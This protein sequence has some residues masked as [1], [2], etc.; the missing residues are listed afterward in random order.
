M[1]KGRTAVL[2]FL[3]IFLSLAWSA[4]AA[5]E[6]GGPHR[7][8]M[9]VVQQGETAFSIARRYGTTVDAITH[10]N[11][12]ADPRQIYVGQQLLIP[13]E[14][15]PVETWSAHVVE[16]GETLAAISAR[17]GVSW[18]SLALSNQVLNPHLI[19]PGQVLRLP[20][21]L[22]RTG[23]LYAVDAGETLLEIAFRH[24]LL[25]WSLVETNKEIN[26]A[27]V[28]PGRWLL[29]PGAQPATMPAPFLAVD[30]TPMP[31]QQGQTLFITVR[32]SEPV[33]LGGSLFDRPLSFF[34]DG[35]V[36]RAV[37]GVHTFADP[38]LYEIALV[39]TD[40]GGRQVSMSTGLVVTDQRYG[41]E[42]IDL[43]PDRSNLLDPALTVAEREK[44]DAVRYTH[45]ASRHWTGPFQ[46]PVEGAIS[47][48]F[49]T[50]RSY[51][52]SPYTSYHSGVDFNVGRGTLVRAPA[53]GV[54]L[55][56]EQLVVRGNVVV[57]DHGY[58]V[59]TGFWHL[60]AFEVASGDVVEVGD[61]I[62]R[63]GNTGLSTGS[64][65][66]WEMWVGGVSVNAL[67]WV[68]PNYPWTDS[69]AAATLP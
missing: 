65:L 67:Q 39:A 4:T 38:G 50:R 53:D 7:P 55:M 58:G 5:A 11:G 47:S 2:I 24:D 69:D 37:V 60:S 68:D 64:H 49:G 6:S 59:L 25:L 44:I 10:A 62:A 51:N 16:P 32:T 52:G 17:Y 26:P 46:Q 57:L 15:G 30:L 12:I 21:P 61:V 22:A 14:L 13:G 27:L 63:A 1:S 8:A 41:Y 18:R 29:V 31:V 34:E 42:R 20:D 54:V 40:E 33:A 66:H 43:S 35:S 19:H 48:Y 28:A 45:T 3:L 56:A 36:Y 9:H 23:S